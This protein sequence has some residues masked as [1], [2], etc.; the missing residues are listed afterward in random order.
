MQSDLD[1]AQ[2]YERQ[3]EAELYEEVANVYTRLVEKDSSAAAMVLRT[4]QH[5]Q[6]AHPAFL[7]A[8]IIAV[9]K[10]QIEDDRYLPDLKD[11]AYLFRDYSETIWLLEEALAHCLSAW[12]LPDITVALDVGNA[13]QDLG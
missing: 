4:I 10:R 8:L 5:K 13:A 9:L 3:E 1:P 11:Y 6:G 2:D 12:G 7:A